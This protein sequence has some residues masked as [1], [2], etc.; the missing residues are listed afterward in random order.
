MDDELKKKPFSRRAL[1]PPFFSYNLIKRRVMIKYVDR[2]NTDS[3]KWDGLADS[4]GS[5]D[6]LPLW[7]ADMD[8]RIDEHII[9]AM[10]NYIELGVPGYYKVPDSYY[11]SFTDWEKNEH[12]LLLDRDWIR[13]SPGI[14]VGFHLAV[15]VLTDPGDAVLISTP[16]YYPFTDAIRNNGREIVS[17]E[18]ENRDGRYYIDFEDFES[19]IIKNNVR[20]Y[21]LC[22]PH[23]PVCRV[24]SEDELR[25][26]LNICRKHNVAV[27][28][29]EIHQDLVFGD[30]K[31]IPAL[32][33]SNESDRIITF[34][35]AS[36]T[37]NIAGL[38]NSFAII[39][40]SKLRDE[41]DAVVKGLRMNQGNALGYIATE[42][43]YRYGKEWLNEVRTIIADNY[44]YVCDSFARQLPGVVMTPLEGTYLAWA[45]FGAYLSPE[46]IQPFMQDNCGIAF[47]YGTW[48]GGDKS[49]SFIR[50]NLATDRSN[51]LEMVN[52]IT[53]AMGNHIK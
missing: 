41:W 47:D 31:N 3:R 1:R 29:D 23:N 20:A 21:I 30:N 32:T 37:F 28:S 40:N 22:S 18:L 8:F 5:E 25:T 15:Q 19:K 16:V 33:M 17:S 39:R 50:I 14:V 35:A 7:I 38:Q 24:W 46:E 27:I 43:A 11:E 49:G 44:T 9:R 10:R 51:I 26:L 4:F 45:D 34:V 13:F 36:K 42:A 12:G 53:E 48:F 52:R 6:L 2:K